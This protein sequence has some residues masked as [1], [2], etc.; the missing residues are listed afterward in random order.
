M[1]SATRAARATAPVS[2]AGGC[3]RLSG[4]AALEVGR[5]LAPRVAPPPPPPPTHAAHAGGA[6]RAGGKGGEG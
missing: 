4:P 5:L 2:G 1:R 3:V 6:A